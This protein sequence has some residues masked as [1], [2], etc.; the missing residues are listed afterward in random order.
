MKHILEIDSVLKSFGEYQLLTDV[1]LKLETDDIVGLFGRNGTGK[2]VL[3]RIIFG[4]MHAD[5]KF[6]RL[7]EK[8][9]L[10]KPYMYPGLISYLPQHS[11][12]PKRLTVEKIVSLYVD[13]KLQEQF[14]KEDMHLQYIRKNK[15]ADLSNGEKRYLE[16]KLLLF[17]PTLFL[18]LDELFNYLS[19]VMVEKVSEMILKYSSGKG[20]IITD[21]NF[22]QVL[23]VSNRY[24][25]L[26]EGTISTFNNKQA[27]IE[28]EYIRSF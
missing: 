25:L 22:E 24:I 6:I 4:T 13:K 12:L 3:M 14:Y 23:K 17:R 7:N 15:I 18:L 5:R 8:K 27:L 10:Q 9:V 21:H 28:Q 16:I 20:I 11:F 26:K 1:Y 2:T 19:P